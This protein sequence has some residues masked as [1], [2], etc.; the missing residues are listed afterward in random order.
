MGRPWRG[1]PATSTVAETEPRDTRNVSRYSLVTQDAL[2][3]FWGIRHPDPRYSQWDES[4]EAYVSG[5]AALDLYETLG[6]R[7][8]IGSSRVRILQ[9]ESDFPSLE[10]VIRLGTGEANS[11]HADAVASV[12]NQHKWDRLGPEKIIIMKSCAGAP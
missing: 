1:G 8:L 11:D 2:D 10:G 6:E 7:V 3:G 5:S 9:T 12:G 4:F